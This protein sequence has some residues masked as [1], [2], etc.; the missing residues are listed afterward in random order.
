MRLI[1][2]IQALL[3]A[4]HSD[5][6]DGMLAEQCVPLSAPVLKVVIEA[7]DA[8]LTT[9][10]EETGEAMG[11]G[12]AGLINIFNPDQIILGGPLSTASDHLLPAIR[13]SVQ[14]YSLPD[15]SQQVEIL[16]S[17]F[18]PDASVVGAVALIVDHILATPTIVER[19]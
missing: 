7:G 1:H 10:V 8:D 4:R 13:N 18:G 12:I 5:F 6:A 15:L 11:V 16:T 19:R 14:K 2:Q 17:A 9:C 3:E